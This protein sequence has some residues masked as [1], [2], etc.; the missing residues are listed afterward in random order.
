MTDRQNTMYLRCQVQG[1]ASLKPHRINGG[2][3]SA[4]QRQRQPSATARFLPVAVPS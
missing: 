4:R 2:P 3:A 1:G